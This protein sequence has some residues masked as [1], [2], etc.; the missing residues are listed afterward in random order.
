[1]R[2]LVSVIVPAY[3]CDRFIEAALTSALTQTYDK[4]EVIVVD[5][6]STDGTAFIV[7]RMMESDA[8]LKLIAQENA[9]VASARNRA[10]TQAHGTL[11]A[12]LDADDV[13]HPSKIEK[14]VRMLLNAPAEV[15]VIYCWAS[16]IDEQGK[17]V[18]R[19]PGGLALNGRIYVNLL[20]GNLLG[21]AST[22]LIRRS[23]LAD[24]GG[25]DPG[26]RARN[27]QGAEDID[28]YL[29]LAQICEFRIIPELLVGYRRTSTSMSMDVPQMRRSLEIHMAR[30]R[31]QNPDLPSALFK[32]QAGHYYRYLATTALAKGDLSSALLCLWR[33]AC[34]DPA[35]FVQS[36][37][38]R[39]F[40]WM[41][42]NKASQPMPFLT[43]SP[44]DIPP[45]D[46]NPVDMRRNEFAA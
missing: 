12:P 34:T 14:Q 11:I 45:S 39:W 36:A 44:T 30:A 4:L 19:W 15:G 32:W 21:N 17:V 5:D 18:R 13:W 3:N 41:N 26:F 2:P 38:R 29:R 7:R 35:K 43:F 6:G 10:I 16:V 23:A 24:I 37:T 40:I 46:T 9:G 20:L 25:Y 22:P 27:A 1:M 31:S 33:S 28:L 42:G 8:R